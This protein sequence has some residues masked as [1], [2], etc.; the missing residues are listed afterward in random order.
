[1]SG[2]E[3]GEKP[4]EDKQM[5]RTEA[6]KLKG[7]VFTGRLK[8]ANRTLSPRPRQTLVVRIINSY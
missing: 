7:S 6:V 3:A 2:G 4:V 1:M 5:K 8:G